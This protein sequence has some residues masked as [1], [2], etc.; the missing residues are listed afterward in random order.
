MQSRAIWAAEGVGRS[1]QRVANGV[2]RC[3]RC[4]HRAWKS[5]S[6]SCDCATTRSPFE[7]TAQCAS[8]CR[9]S[10]HSSAESTNCW[11]NAASVFT[12]DAIESRAAS[13]A[14]CVGSSTCEIAPSSRRDATDVGAR[15]A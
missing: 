15:G 3:G 12:C 11:P 5:E 10:S 7:K 13:R 4:I 9:K 2:R 14:A 8:R 6:Q 1:S